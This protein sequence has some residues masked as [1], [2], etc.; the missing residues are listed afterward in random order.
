ML[1]G[2]SLY[3]RGQRGLCQA[4]RWEWHL[5]ALSLPLREQR[6]RDT[7]EWK[8]SGPVWTWAQRGW[9]A[10]PYA[11]VRWLREQTDLSKASQ[12]TGSSPQGLRTAHTCTLAA[13]SPSR[14]CW[15][16]L[17]WRRHGEVQRPLGAGLTGDSK[18]RPGWGQTAVSCVPSSKGSVLWGRG[19]QYSPWRPPGIAKLGWDAPLEAGD[20]AGVGHSWLLPGAKPIGLVTFWARR[21]SVGGCPAIAEQHPWLPPAR[22]RY[23]SALQV[24]ASKKC[25]ESTVEP[26][27]A[28]PGSKKAGQKKGSPKY[29]KEA[30]TSLSRRNWNLYILTRHLPTAILPGIPLFLR[31]GSSL[32]PGAAGFSSSAAQIQLAFPSSQASHSSVPSS[33]MTSRPGSLARVPLSTE[34]PYMCPALG[35]GSSSRGL[36]P[37]VAWALVPTFPGPGSQGPAEQAGG[38]LGTAG[39]LGLGRRWGQPSHLPGV[40]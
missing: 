25:P 23:H 39:S 31:N 17:G 38:G 33:V 35:L 30:G 19:H 4:A 1:S 22:C 15:Y 28:R 32:C 12:W 9:D 18:F 13:L 20:R 5:P 11:M 29:Q 40:G 3:W 8:T 27:R 14:P 36:L 21:F 24:T 37:C 34:S 7:E 16:L 6:A 2:C 26:G 10:W